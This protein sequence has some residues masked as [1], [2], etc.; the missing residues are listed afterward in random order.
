MTE[1]VIP[2]LKNEWLRRVPVIRGLG[3][4]TQPLR[5]FEIYYNQYRGHRKLGG[6]V[7]SVIHRGQQWKKTEKSAKA[8]PA[9]IE[10]GFFADTQITAYRLPAR[11]LCR[12]PPMSPRAPAHLAAC[13]RPSSPPMLHR[14]IHVPLSDSPTASCRRPWGRSRPALPQPMSHAHLTPAHRCLTRTT[15]VTPGSPADRGRR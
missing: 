11:P 8:V 1:R 3:H 12:P 14:L 6:A 15:G 9:T 13:S 4:L 7:P 2:T 10:R 5:D